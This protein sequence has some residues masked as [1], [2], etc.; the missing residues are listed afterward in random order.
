MIFHPSLC[1]RCR[2]IE[3]I[4]SEDR[5]SSHPVCCSCGGPVTVLP[6]DGYP[7]G[8]V[9]LF[10]ELLTQLEGSGIVG[11]E[12]EQ[13][14][15]S[16]EGARLCFDEAEALRVVAFRVPALS[17]LVPLLIAS[18]GRPRHALSMLDTILRALA[19][20][21]RASGI[22]RAPRS[23]LGSES[24]EDADGWQEVG[25]LPQTWRDYRRR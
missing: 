13:L 7:E 20:K 24:N 10:N 19:R 25:P 11:A 17:P 16:V 6:V 2:S 9:L 18:P 22:V 8:D 21:R 23:A 1:D 14:A 15:L 3:L 5:I 4:S 12:A